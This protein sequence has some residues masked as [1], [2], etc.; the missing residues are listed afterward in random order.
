MS[1]F[2]HTNSF[3]L[4]VYTNKNSYVF[5]TAA[6]KASQCFND[7]RKVGI[8]YD[9][10]N[11]D[12]KMRLEWLKKYKNMKIL[13]IAPRIKT[14]KMDDKIFTCEKMADSKYI[15]NCYYDFE[16]I[17]KD[18][19]ENQL[20]FVKKRNSTGSKGVS[21]IKYKNLK[22]SDLKNTVLQENIMNPDL[23]D[24]RRYKIRM[25]TVIYKKQV[26]FYNN[27]LSTVSAVPFVYNLDVIDDSYITKMNIIYQSND[28][29]WFDL[30]SQPNRDAIFDNMLDSLK[31]FEKMYKQEIEKIEDNEFAVLGFDYIV[32]A[33][34]NVQ[35]IEI[36]HRS[37][38]QHPK[39]ITDNVDVG[40]F[41]ELFKLFT[42]DT[43]ENTDFINITNYENNENIKLDITLDKEE[44]VEEEN[45]EEDVKE[46]VKEATLDDDSLT[47]YDNKLLEQLDL[48]VSKLIKMK[49]KQYVYIKED[50]LGGLLYEPDDFSKYKNDLKFKIKNQGRLEIKEG[51]YYFKENI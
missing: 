43:H 39:E 13:S 24:G 11:A 38:Y 28:I 17:P 19:D 29:K 27:G 46:D 4:L 50:D 21:I 25:Y 35:I 18:T 51:K 22:D 31:D 44:S 34:C 48:N 30:N 16:G 14:L 9:D 45:V 3:L 23:Y 10:F 26:Y 15:P 36:N 32:D 20:F 49:N 40:M 7:N 1:E 41:V 33:D 6:E 12:P 5:N 42:T 2:L 47:D 8:I 37:N